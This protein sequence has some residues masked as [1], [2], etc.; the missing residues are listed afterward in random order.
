[1][2]PPVQRPVNDNFSNRV[3]IPFGVTTVTGTLQNATFENGELSY[4]SMFGGTLWWSWRPPTN[5][6]AFIDGRHPPFGPS[7]AVF[8]GT[9]FPNL[10]CVASAEHFQLPLRFEA[11]PD[12]IYAF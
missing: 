3:A 8:T 7:I 9:N 6:A 11:D 1:V 4:M 12:R 10:T 2:T 5:C